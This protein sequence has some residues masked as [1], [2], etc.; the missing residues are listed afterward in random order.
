M[1][2][3]IRIPSLQ[4]RI[5]AKD[6]ESEAR[7]RTVEVLAARGLGLQA[8]DAA[9]RQEHG[10]HAESISMGSAFEQ[11]LGGNGSATGPRLR[12]AV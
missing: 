7:E 12:G 4:K 10:R 9:V 8:R 3:G 2:F 11:P 1:K 6:T 5:A